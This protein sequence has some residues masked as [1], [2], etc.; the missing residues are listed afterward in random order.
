MKSAITK[1]GACEP[2]SEP[3][4][5]THVTR[6]CAWTGD[7]P[8]VEWKGQALPARWVMGVSR[9][10]LESAARA[11]GEAI[12]GCTHDGTLVVMALL[13]SDLQ[14][15]AGE[16]HDGVTVNGREIVLRADD[17]LVLQCGDACITL[18]KEGALTIRGRR[19]ET[20][21]RGANRIRGGTVE[22][23]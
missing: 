12:V 1:M 4:L 19:V 14:A 23:N 9:T 5:V 11:K 17:R 6:L 20:R 22:I 2:E 3:A 15:H 7:S 10:A 21:A 16:S 18:T 8:L 13:A